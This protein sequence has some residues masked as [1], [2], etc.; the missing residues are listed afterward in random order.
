L[1]LVSSCSK[2]FF[3]HKF[4]TNFLL[5][6]W[7]HLKASWSHLEKQVLVLVENKNLVETQ[8]DKYHT[9]ELTIP[10]Q[11]MVILSTFKQFPWSWC[12]IWAPNTPAIEKNCKTTNTVVAISSHEDTPKPP[13]ILPL[14]MT[15]VLIEFY[16]N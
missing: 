9:I 5:P 13:P 6:Y 16:K 11:V 8:Y 12:D 2:I 1:E 15:K 4:Q 10:Q 7:H 14:T 3:I